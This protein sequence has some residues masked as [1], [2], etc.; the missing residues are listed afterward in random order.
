[1]GAGGGSAQVG[2]VAAG[3]W[4]ACRPL[5]RSC[6]CGARSG[7]Y[8]TPYKDFEVTEFRSSATAAA[9]AVPGQAQRSGVVPVPPGLALAW[10]LTYEGIK[11]ASLGTAVWQGSVS[12]AAVQ[13]CCRRFEEAEALVRS[14]VTAIAS[15][16][17]KRITRL[18]SSHGFNW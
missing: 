13:Y 6:R 3:L 11:L 16:G 9:E 2:T 7:L 18:C 17:G 14:S 10:L 4:T 5:S 12:K 15:I 1:M 8:E